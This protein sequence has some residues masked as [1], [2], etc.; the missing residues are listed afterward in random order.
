MGGTLKRHLPIHE[1]RS[2]LET[3]FS[4]VKDDQAN[5]SKTPFWRKSK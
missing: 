5:G 1:V 4:A 2:I 3:N